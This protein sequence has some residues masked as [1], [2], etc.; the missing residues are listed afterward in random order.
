MSKNQSTIANKLRILKLP[1][2][3]KRKLVR[4]SLTERHARALLRLHDETAQLRLIDRIVREG[5]SV[6]ETEDL[7]E[8]ELNR[9]YGEEKDSPQMKMRCG[10]RI[11]VNT[12]KR[13]VGKMTAMG[14]KTEYKT[15]EY[16]DRIA[17]TITVMK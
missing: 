7:V 1:I 12:L 4:H 9:L 3:V 14:A 11:Y 16:D 2:S 5:L 13:A 6:K 17:V 15:V 10:Y 8:H